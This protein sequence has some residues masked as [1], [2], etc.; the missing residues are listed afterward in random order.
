[1]P[2]GF[3]PSNVCLP[4]VKVSQV[5]P[6]AVFAL[7]EVRVAVELGQLLRRE[8]RPSMET[9]RVLADQELQ[10]TGLLKGHQGHVTLCWH[11]AERRLPTL[12]ELT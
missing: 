11:R 6:S 10:Q 2:S 5:L 8:A 12:R 4:R 3:M 9:V 1:M 7:L